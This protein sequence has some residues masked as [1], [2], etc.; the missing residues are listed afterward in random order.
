MRKKISFYF[1]LTRSLFKLLSTIFFSY[2]FQFIAF[3]NSIAVLVLELN[4]IRN[5]VLV[6]QYLQSKIVDFPLKMGFVL[7]I[8][9]NNTSKNAITIAKQSAK[10]TKYKI[11]FKLNVDDEMKV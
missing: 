2:F 1:G 11:T 4:C 6:R 10:K 9:I 8:I 3:Y 7:K 5:N